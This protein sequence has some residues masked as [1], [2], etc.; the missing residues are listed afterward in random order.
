[1]DYDKG[2]PACTMTMDGTI[3]NNGTFV[4]GIWSDNCWGINRNGTWTSVGGAAS[5]ATFDWGSQVNA[6]KCIGK[7]GKPILNIT[8]KVINDTDSGIK[9]NW[10]TDSYNRQVQV[11]K[12]L[13]G[14]FCVV[15]RYEG[16]FN[17]WPNVSSPNGTTVLSGSEV[18]TMQGG[19]IGHFSGTLK[20]DP[21]YPR[22]GN[23][24]TFNFTSDPSFSWLNTYFDGASSNYYDS[25][26]GWI[27]HG[28]QNGTWINSFDG[29]FG[30]IQ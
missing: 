20:S 28:G 1:M 6:D 7:V 29:N 15:G 10:A 16:K 4:N 11:W 22:F 8:Y 27:Y 26:W 9:G 13:N 21:D 3:A 12:L 2:V 25:W 14:N 24:G 5:I 17:A 18:G 19:R 23:I 30:D